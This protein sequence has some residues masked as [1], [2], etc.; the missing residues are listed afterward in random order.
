M[1]NPRKLNEVFVLDDE[2]KRRIVKAG[3][4]VGL[5]PPHKESAT[6][7]NFMAQEHYDF[8]KNWLGG[9]GPFTISWIGQWPCGRIML[10]LKTERSE[11]GA[12]ANDFRYVET[13][14]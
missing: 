1:G 4:L 12:Y 7:E 6:Y 8:L 14:R 10:Y 5:L 13:A 2:G 9:E 3:D 11:P